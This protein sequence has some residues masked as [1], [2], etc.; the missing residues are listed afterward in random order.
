MSNSD[1]KPGMNMDLASRSIWITWFIDGLEKYLSVTEAQM[2]EAQ[3]LECQTLRLQ[4]PA[5]EDEEGIDEFRREIASLN[6]LYELNLIPATRYSFVVLLHIL[7]ETQLRVFCADLQ[8]QRGLPKIS[9]KDFRGSAVEQAEL[10]LSKLA[11]VR[12]QD[13]PEWEQLRTLQKVRACVVHTYGRVDE[14]RD[15]NFLRE[16]TK[17]GVGLSIGYEGRISVNK[18]FCE[19]QLINLRNLFQQL[20]TAVGW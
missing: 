11:G 10:F 5:S 2:E 17:K 18:V 9:V 13:F 16:L 19:Q 7:L 8:I 1:Q 3:R 6:N 12:P 14:S 4:G 15:E 20:F